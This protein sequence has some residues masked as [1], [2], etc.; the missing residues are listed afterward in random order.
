[1]RSFYLLIVGL[2]FHLSSWCQSAP[3]D[4]N[5]TKVQNV[6]ENKDDEDFRL[7]RGGG[8]YSSF[9]Y[10]LRND[11]LWYAGTNLYTTVIPLANVDFERKMYFLE[12]SLY[13]TKDNDKCIEVPLYAIK[14]RLYEKEFEIEAFK[15]LEEGTIDFT[16][17]ILPDKAFAEAFIKYLKEHR[18]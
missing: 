14:G 6:L 16:N 12:S 13:K 2:C 5:V 3:K 18:P 1:M 4:E 9:K 8:S 11:T 15:K 7:F 17:L 10:F